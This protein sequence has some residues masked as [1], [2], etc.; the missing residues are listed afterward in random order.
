MDFVSACDKCGRTLDE[1]HAIP[2]VGRWISDF[3]KVA[4]DVEYLHRAFLRL[5]T[6][7]SLDDWCQ[8]MANQTTVT[9]LRITYS[10]KLNALPRSLGKL[11]RL[12]YLEIK[13]NT[14]KLDDGSL[15]L[16]QTLS[17]K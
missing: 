11:Q 13:Y 7:D 4:T 15:D 5:L 8:T 6:H 2:I 3:S 12:E 14:T 17:G 9:E 1:G 10:K 16:G